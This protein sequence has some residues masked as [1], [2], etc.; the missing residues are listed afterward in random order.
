[1]RRRLPPLNAVKAF[2]ATARSESFTHAAAELCVTPAAVSQQVKALEATLGVALFKRERRRLVLTE[3]GREYLPVVRDALDQIAVGTNRLVERRSAH[4][5]TVSTSPDFAAKWL[6][7]RLARFSERYPKIDLRVDTTAH[8]VDLAR[9]HVDLAIRHG[10]GQWPGLD[11]VRLYAERLFPV[12]SPRL[13]ADHNG[14]IAASDLLKL[15]LLRLDGWQNWRR[16]FDAAGIPNFVARGPVLSQASML[17]DAAVEGQ[18]VALARTA[19]AAWDLVNGRLMIPVAISV[20]V[21]KTY[22]V[23]CLRATADVPKVRA[24]REWMMAEAADDAQRL[25]VSAHQTKPAH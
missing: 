6:L 12:C 20:S 25:A 9:D 3:A 13:I 15:P 23:A 14:G 16:W 24:F 18:G 21:Q 22:W 4:T 1:M 19:L 5:L 11:A 17:I 8:H 2:E 10:D 7:P